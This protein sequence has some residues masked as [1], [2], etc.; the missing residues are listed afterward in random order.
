VGDKSAFCRGEEQ[1]WKV[2][3]IKTAA[4]TKL[5]EAE[6]LNALDPE[7]RSFPVEDLIVVAEFN[8]YI[9]P[10]LVSTGKVERGGDKSFHT[11][12]NAE[13]LKLKISIGTKMVGSYLR[14]APHGRSG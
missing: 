2:L 5:A 10:D 4:S 14:A 13:N 11:V 9:Y 8:D 1:R 3:S 6:M 7:R 12:I